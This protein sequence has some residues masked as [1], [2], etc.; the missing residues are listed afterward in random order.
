MTAL[1]PAPLEPAV[2]EDGTCAGCG[3]PRRLDQARPYRDHA[4][5]DPFCSAKC[6]RAWYGC[7]L[8]DLRETAGARAAAE[9]AAARFRAAHPFRRKA[10]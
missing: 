8:E 7:P 3:K 6:A 1:A 9:Q 10:S 2:P 5:V 4:E